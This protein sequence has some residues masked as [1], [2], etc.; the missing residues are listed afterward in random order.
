MDDDDP[1]PFYQIF[2]QVLP[3]RRRPAV[4]WC[5]PP[6]LRV[7]PAPGHRADLLLTGREHLLQ[8]GLLQ[9]SYLKNLGKELEEIPKD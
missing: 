7:P 1:L 8:G 9:V 5:L 4:A 2:H 6:L 3:T